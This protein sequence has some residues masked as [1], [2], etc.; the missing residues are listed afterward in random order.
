MEST[1]RSH[2]DFRQNIAI[3]LLA[4]SAVLLFAQTQLYNLGTGPDLFDGTIPAELQ[5]TGEQ[6]PL[7]APVRIAVSGPYGRYA[8]TSMNTLQPEFEPLG[9]LLN[10]VL[11]SARAFKPCTVQDF[12]AALSADLSVYYDFCVPLPLP[13]L[14]GLLG[15]AVTN[16]SISARRLIIAPENENVYLYLWDN[17]VGYF[18]SSTAVSIRSLQTAAGHYEQGSAFFALDHT[19]PGTEALDPFSLFPGELLPEGLPLLSAA[20]LPHSTDDL[21]TSLNFNPRTNLRYPESDGT[22]VIVEGERTLSISPSGRLHYQSGGESVLT[23]KAF[24]PQAPSLQEAVSGVS[25]LL[26][27]L[28]DDSHVLFLRSVTQEDA[29]TVLQFDYQW[30]GIPILFADG[31]PAAEV[32]LTG[33]TVSELLFRFRQYAESGQEAPLLPLRQAIAIAAKNPGAELILSYADRGG[34]SVSAVWLA[35]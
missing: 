25:L 17:D 13:V 5:L 27:G 15:S 28:I 35:R 33:S 32:S 18:R 7:S 3:T 30:N 14:A 19:L 2:R 29:S 12:T 24:D 8:S 6:I 9:T 10:E 11:G 31:Q 21:L 23:I 16:E 1:Q 4:V 34:G 26:N 20:S 22:E